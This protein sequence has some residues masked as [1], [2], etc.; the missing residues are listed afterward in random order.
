MTASS[1]PRVIKDYD[2]LDEATQN[3]IKL[4]Y[5]DGFSQYLISYTN[6]DGM[7]V[8]ALPF[9]TDEKNYLVRM[10]SQEAVDI[11]SEDEF[12]DDVLKVDDAVRQGYD[13]ELA[14]TEEEAEEPY[15][16][17]SIDELEEDDIE[18]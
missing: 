1:K 9:E 2:K 8:S 7:L 5:P 16:D 10:T 6:K 13:D 18:I 12:D 15:D 4:A 3:Q 17:A 14:Y 11:V